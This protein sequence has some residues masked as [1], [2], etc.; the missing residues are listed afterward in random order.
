M[1]LASVASVIVIDRGRVICEEGGQSE[2]VWA[3][4]AGKYSAN[5][6]EK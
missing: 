3:S 1:D 4:V 6:R 2:L 5:I